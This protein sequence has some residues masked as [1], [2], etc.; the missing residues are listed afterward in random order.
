[1]LDGVRHDLAHE[2]A[3]IGGKVGEAT[4]LAYGIAAVAEMCHRPREIW[5]RRVTEDRGTPQ[6]WTVMATDGEAVIGLHGEIDL[7]VAPALDAELIEQ[8]AALTGDLVLDCSD[9]TFIDSTGL[10]ALIL[11]RQ[12]LEADHR[13]LVLRN[14][15][16]ACRRPIEI[17]GLTEVLGV[18]P[19]E[20]RTDTRGDRSA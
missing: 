7:A 10:T 3:T 1:M 17:C 6:A 19:E 9:L 12:R 2:Q 16:D 13:A 4:L 14:V 8:A 18:V 11:V 20:H 15:S 5:C